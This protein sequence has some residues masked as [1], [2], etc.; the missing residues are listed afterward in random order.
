MR[1]MSSDEIISKS[2]LYCVITSSL[3]FLLRKMSSISR[4]CGWKLLESLDLR[5]SEKRKN[6]LK[7]ENGKQ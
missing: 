1:N 4:N 7:I 5:L 6:E 2:K 3:C